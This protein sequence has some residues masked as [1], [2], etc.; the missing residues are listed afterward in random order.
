MS[1]IIFDATNVP[2][3]GE[4]QIWTKGK[5]R[6]V[7]PASEMKSSKSGGGQVIHFDF[8][9]MDAPY[10]GLTLKHTVNFTNSNSDAE[11]IGKS[12]LSA[13]CWAV[14]TPKITDTSNLHGKPLMI[15]VD[16]EFVPSVGPD[17][18]SLKDDKGNA[19]GKT[20]NRI[21]GYFNE[22]GSAVKATPVAAAAPPAFLQQAQ[23][24]PVAPTPPPA[25]TRKFHVYFQGVVKTQP[26]APLD[27]E[28]VKAL[29][30]QVADP[31]YMLS[32]NGGEW[33]LASTVLEAAP[34]VLATPT[35]PPWAPKV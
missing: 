20:Y 16:T 31:S 26:T 27:L 35:I 30:F 21:I 25:D 28:G 33:V 1:A 18:Q 2:I 8:K 29:G 23:P 4:R 9:A 34:A 12:E 22:D 15:D 17:S 19:I 5:Y 10:L 32:I 3:A 24:G 6:V 14:K 13:I 7:I 11:R